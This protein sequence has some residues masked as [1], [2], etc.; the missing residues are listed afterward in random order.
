VQGVNR[1]GPASHTQCLQSSQK[2]GEQ[3]TPAGNVD[4]AK[5]VQLKGKA[6]DL[7]SHVTGLLCCVEAECHFCYLRDSGVYVHESCCLGNQ[8]HPLTYVGRRRFW[9]GPLPNMVS[10]FR[11]SGYKT[12]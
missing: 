9:Y 12:P 6:N 5:C 8:R 1:L 4:L 11:D 7:L 10:D 3:R 2:P